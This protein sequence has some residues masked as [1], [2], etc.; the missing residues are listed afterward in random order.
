MAARA[1]KLWYTGGNAHNVEETVKNTV[2]LLGAL[3]I[4]A[5]MALTACG[6]KPAAG[7]ADLEGITWS[8]LSYGTPDSPKVLVDDTEITLEFDLAEGRISGSA[9]C[10]SYFSEITIKGDRLTTSVVGNTE[11]YCMN[12]NGVMEQEVAYVTALSLVESYHVQD[13]QLRITCTDGQVLV[14]NATA[15]G[16]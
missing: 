12:P 1:S 8:L 2:K 9:G 16:R 5:A 3:V 4:L 13:G 10:N 11:M 6:G 15:G 14:Y 7:A